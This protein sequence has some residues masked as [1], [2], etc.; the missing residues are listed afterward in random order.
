MEYWFNSFIADTGLIPDGDWQVPE[1]EGPGR[2][3]R[4]APEGTEGGSSPHGSVEL[5]WDIDSDF[6][7]LSDK[8]ITDTKATVAQAA[9]Q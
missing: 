9:E 3:E 7:P 5:E 1:Y 4:G 8:V 2:E 6:T